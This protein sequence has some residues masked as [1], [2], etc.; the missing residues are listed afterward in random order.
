M[1]D[2]RHPLCKE[3]LVT[4]D[5]VPPGYQQAAEE[6]RGHLIALRG[7]APFLAP[8]DAHLLVQWLDEGILVSSILRALERA[9]DSRRKRRSRVPLN[10]RHA[11]RHLGK[12]T[13]GV[14]RCSPAQQNDQVSAHPLQP[15][16]HALLA[17]ASD[18]PQRESLRQ[19]AK[20]LTSLAADDQDALIREVLGCYRLFFEAL[21]R[22]L[23]S[24]EREKEIQ[25][26]ICELGDLALYVDEASL[27]ASAEE[28]ARDKQRASYPWLTAATL[29]DLLNA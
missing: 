12:P 23:T 7:G 10:L 11:N 4:S 1:I 15:L 8:D 3:T 2:R 5:V 16:A 14:L 27:L 24:E 9:A 22:D 26:S 6:V 17:Q 20:E 18:D 29:W 25:D 13:K 28:R 21:W 19:M